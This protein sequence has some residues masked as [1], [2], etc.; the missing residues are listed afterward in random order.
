MKLSAPDA[1]EPGARSEGA[2]IRF[3][4]WLVE[5]PENSQPRELRVLRWLLRAVGFLLAAFVAGEAGL[6]DTGSGMGS[7]G[8]AGG[9]D[10]PRKPSA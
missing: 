2:V 3:L 5:P 1:P 7:G 8:G 9:K 6:N 4:R 10:K